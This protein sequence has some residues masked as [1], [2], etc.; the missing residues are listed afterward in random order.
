VPRRPARCRAC[1]WRCPWPPR[2][3]GRA[4]PG[5]T[6]APSA[7]RGAPRPTAVR[8]RSASPQRPPAGRPRV[9]ISRCR[10][11]PHRCGPPG[12]SSRDAGVL[13][14]LFAWS[15][16]IPDTASSRQLHHIDAAL[17]GRTAGMQASSPRCSPGPRR[18][19][20]PPA[21]PPP[22]LVGCPN[23]Q[24]SEGEEVQLE[25]AGPFEMSGEGEEKRCE[26]LRRVEKR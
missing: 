24:T 6:P 14:S 4:S 8:Q 21:A 17:Q 1:T 15:K 5:R 22:P 10:A 9:I 2:Q 11:S 7:R 13:S 18:S 23:C 25:K 3:E 26:A 16:A 20:T 19:P 12:T